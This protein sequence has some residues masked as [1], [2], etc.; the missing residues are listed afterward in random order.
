MNQQGLK[1]VLRINAGFSI[2]SG[3]LL[4]VDAGMLSTL[5]GEA[6]PWIFR[7][8]GIGLLLFAADI[9]VTC[10]QPEIPRWKALYF[11]IG[12]F[13]WVAGSALVLIAAPMTTLAAVLLVGIALIVLGFGVLQVRQ[14]RGPA[15]A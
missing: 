14:I 5:F 7:G 12:D 2:L 8:I 6:N 10:R 15:R 3:L 1:K 4:I 11:S 9:V 13:G